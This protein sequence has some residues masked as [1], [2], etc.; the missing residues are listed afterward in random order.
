MGKRVKTD[1][2]IAVAYVRVS[3]DDQKLGPEAQ[4]AAIQAWA[5]R[6]GIMIAVWCADEGVSGAS[7]ISDRPGLVA[8]LAALKTH[9]AGVLVAAKRDRLARDVMVAATLDQAT[10]KAGARVRTAD[11]LSDT[12]GP[13]GEFMRTV[14]DGA[15]QYERAMI[16]AR[17]KAALAAK[18]AKGER[19][20]Q[21]PY[22]WRVSDDGVRLEPVASEQEI[23]ATVRAMRASGVRVSAILT[24]LASR[25]V[26]TRTGK[27]FIR[28][29]V[30]RILA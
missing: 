12:A 17:T 19:V 14:I 11:G 13:E 25:G 15:A 4:R 22:G 9:G 28:N 18:R 6:E 24:T 27:A 20:G 1:S 2:R 8:A 23:I 26:T 10:R 16:R 7:Q 5:A 30:E 29:Q 21:V 3:T